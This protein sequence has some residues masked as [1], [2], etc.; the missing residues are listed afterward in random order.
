LSTGPGA[1]L[2]SRFLSQLPAPGSS[3]RDRKI[4]IQPCLDQQELKEQFETNKIDFIVIEIESGLLRLG[5]K[6]PE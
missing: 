5:E 3:S 2:R 6:L 4:C 1:T